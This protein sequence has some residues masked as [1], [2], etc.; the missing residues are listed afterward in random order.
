M[1]AHM[2][3]LGRHSRHKHATRPKGIVAVLF[4]VLLVFVMAMVAFSVD[5]GYMF[6]VQSELD[7]A[8]DAG[9]L[10]GAGTLVDGQVQA[11]QTVY[12]F[13]GLNL[14]GREA[15][16]PAD[17]EVETGV[18]DPTTRSFQASPNPPSA[19]RVSA[20]R[21]RQSLF[22][23]RVLGHDDFD[24]QSEAIAVYQPRDIMLV[25]DY[26]AS[27]NDDS[28]LRHISTI[29]QSA[30]EANLLQIY[31][32]LGSP[33][34]GNMQ[35]NPVYISSDN[36]YTVKTIL[37]LNNVAYPFPSGSWDD[38]VYYVRTSG[39]LSN[40]GYRKDYGYLTLVNYWL[41]RRPM[42]SETPTL[43]QTSEQPITAVKDSV[44]VFLAYLQEVD[45]DDRL[46]LSVY[47]S[48][49]DTAKLEAGL[50]NNFQQ[51]EDISR[52][53]QA[54]HY[55]RMTNI[56]AG[57]QTSRIELEDNSRPGAFKM[58]V[59]MTDGIANLPGDSAA[60][61]SFALQQAQLCA[62]KNYPIVTVSLGSGA[63]T[64]LMDQIAAI[65]NGV[66]FNIPGGQSVSQYEQDLK[67]V[68]REIASDRP[69]Q[70]VK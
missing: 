64:A 58:I 11:E 65:T 6:T 16:S 45:T 41:E 4:A 43:W 8:V 50:T 51:V 62:D 25:L 27:M 54:G 66:H 31:Q 35:W 33:G 42:Y 22:F 14:V 21:L 38:Y 9:A 12:D 29:G 24:V 17:I 47:T 55:D 67:D 2:P 7:R 69:L 13:I 59:L 10:A 52:E 49:S 61:R 26:S 70:L 46:G 36:T 53:R 5:M 44:T 48:A 15:V 18:W 28:E 56:G 34:F 68:F 3:G 19:I 57:I 63:D 40:A 60:A 37:G 23:A 30:V 1:R 32:E 39:Y 20:K